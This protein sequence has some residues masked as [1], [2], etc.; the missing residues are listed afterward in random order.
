MQ[1]CSTSGLR[2]LAARAAAGFALSLASLPA[3]AGSTVGFPEY[4]SLSPDG[5]RVVF[6]WA[7]DLWAMS[8]EGG[9]AMRLTSH[10]ADERRSAFSPDG[11]HI[12]FESDRVGSRSIYVMP[13][14]EIGDSAPGGPVVGGEISRVTVAPTGQ[15]LGG[16]TADGESV[17]FSSNQ[18]PSI[19]RMARMFTAPVD[20]G[21]V[22]RVTPA[23][24]TLPRQ[25]A[26]GTVIFNRGYWNWERPAYRGP[27]DL[28]LWTMSPDGTFTQ[29]TLSDGND[30]DGHLLPDGSIV[31]VSSRDGQNNVWHLGAKTDDRGTSLRQLTRFAPTQAEGTIAHGVRDLAV[32]A[33]GTTAAFCVWDTLYTLDLTDAA[34]EPVALAPIA[35]VDSD[36]LDHD[37]MDLDRRV[38]EAAMSPDG[39]TMAVAARGEIFVRSTKDDRPTRRVTETVA[40]ERDLAW[41]PDNARLYFA[42]DES[43]RYAI[44][45]AT[46]TLARP[47]LEPADPEEEAVESAEPAE[48]EAAA[49]E[50]PAAETQAD[51]DAEADATDEPADGEPKDEDAD[52]KDSDKKDADKKDADKKD[53]DEPKPGERWRDALRFETRQL[54]ANEQHD[55]RSPTPSPDGMSLL[56]IRGRGDIVHRDLKTGEERVLL[57]S[58]AAPDVIWAANSTHIV[59]SVEDLDFNSDIF[60][61]DVTDPDAEPINLTRHPDYDTS[62]QLT[63]DGTMLTFISDRGGQSWEFDVY[64]VYLDREI[65]GLTAYELDEYFADAGK[66]AKKRKPID[67]VSFDEPAD[68]GAEGE[69]GEENADDDTSEATDE[70]DAFAPDAHYAFRRV[71]RLT[72]LGNVGNLS[73]TP[74][75]ERIAFTASIDGSRALY[76]VDFRGQERKTVRS[77]GVSGVATNLGGTKLTYVASGQAHASAPTGGKATTYDIDAAVVVDIADQQGQKFLEAARTLG[78]NFYHPTLKD[79]DW[80]KL[81]ERYKS[82]AMQTRTTDAFNRIGEMLFGELNGSH[83]GMWGGGG[84]SGESESIGALGVRTEPVP[85]GYRITHVM[86]R[87]PA[88]RP[89]S[90]LMVGDII[91]A[92]DST[93]IAEAGGMPEIDMVAAMAGTAGRETLIERI[94]ADEF[95]STHVL[96]VPASAGSVRGLAYLE[97]V[98]RRRAMVEELSEGKLGYLHIQSMGMASVLDYERDLYAAANGKL[99]LV[100]DV[101]DNGGGWTT[102]ILLASLTAPAH[103]YTIPRGASESEVDRLTYPRDR[104]LIYAY[105][106]PLSVLINENSFSNAEIFAHSIKTT[107]RGTLVG[108]QT[109]G[110]VISTGSFTLIDGTRVR[111]PFRGWFLPDGTD[112]ENN[113]AVP[114]IDVPISPADEAAGRDPQLEAAVKELLGRSIAFERELDRAPSARR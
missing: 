83:L 100:I 57:E 85:G 37:R 71:R 101:R 66:A 79:L 107:G 103:A 72:S 97:E 87:S 64:G 23:F 69:E 50:T 22:E 80:P 41:S 6:C 59:Y 78:D 102:D 68:D 51:G 113:G 98:E 29:R 73:M 9:V 38:G 112:M 12:A 47:D 76:S 61:L 10:P 55:L 56:Y 32:S 63:A 114:D 28:D 58:W 81:T 39:N 40:R 74:S 89:S 90:E 92:I 95:A 84:Y 3:I 77:G 60:L 31:F 99:G 70:D 62:P 26:D 109:F 42:S 15:T 34:A 5:E 91:T 35:S 45:E 111:M 1:F 106:R 17:I 104:R 86:D 96:I 88:A 67:P 30:G 52:E 110:G 65:E 44:Y 93:R 33:D 13:L 48:D 43:G 21:P 36:A 53:K 49:D 82:L 27:G 46:V 105:Q 7:G 94:P 2:P 75:G 18:D 19:Y 20:G 16:F 54:V 24:G 108:T 25:G 8:T 4:P 11:T 14:I